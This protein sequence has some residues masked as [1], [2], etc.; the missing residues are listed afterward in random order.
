M[1][2]LSR[3]FASRF[4]RF[5][6]VGAAGFLVNEAALWYALRHLQFDPYSGGVFSFLVA[7]TF[8]WLGNRFIT[9]RDRAARGIQ[10]IGTEW[11]RFLGANALGFLGNYAVYAGL[12]RFAAPPANNPYLALVCGTIA[13]LAFNFVLSSR[14]VFR[15]RNS[16][17]CR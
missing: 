3:L 13:A 7:V 11:A 12:I 1:N 5:A 17:D 8:T 4:I 15:S 14:F 10:G 9:F 6:I 2:L 16:P